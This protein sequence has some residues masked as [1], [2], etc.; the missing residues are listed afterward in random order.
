M[1]TPTLTGLADRSHLM[2]AAI[3]LETH[4]QDVVNL[5][6]W[7][8]IEQAV[9]VGHSYGG[10]VISGAAEQLEGRLAALAYVDAFLPQDGQ[11]GFD[12]LNAQQQAAVLEAQARGEL[13]RP[14][15]TSTALRIQHP[16]DAAWVDAQITPQPIGVSMQPIRLNGARERVQSKLY[17]RTPCFPQ[18]LFDAA[19]AQCATDAGWKTAVMHDCGHDPMIDQPETLCFL[20]EQL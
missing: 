3:T 5:F 14:G 4:V 1:Y 9:L 2:S 17:I 6:R 19:L 15:P 7:E 8:E 20:L 10:W 16:D 18:P 13:S 12:L 11:R